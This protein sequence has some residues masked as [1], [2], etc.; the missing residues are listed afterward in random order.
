MN[1]TLG[2][3][4]GSGG[5]GSSGAIWSTELRARGIG[6]FFGAAFLALWL[7]GWLVGECFAL[8]MAGGILVK[9]LAPGVLAQLGPKIVMP[10]GMAAAGIL[11][12][13]ALWLTLWTV[14]GIAAFAQLMRMLGGV[15][16]IELHPT[17]LLVRR[18][19]IIGQSTTRIPIERVID[20]RLSP[21]KALV[22]ET[23]DR[24]ETLSDLEG[25]EQRTAAMI[26]LRP[27]VRSLRSDSRPLRERLA[28]DVPEGWSD[29]AADVMAGGHSGFNAVLVSRNR[30]RTGA[31]VFL[32]L[33]A[34]IPAGIIGSALRDTVFLRPGVEVT[35]AGLIGPLV[36]L[37]VLALIGAAHWTWR[38]E[39]RV[40]T[41][42]IETY[43]EVLW[44]RH[45]KLYESARLELEAGSDS[46]GDAWYKLEV[47]SGA[48]HGTLASASDYSGPRRLGMW[49][50][51]RLGSE[52]TLPREL[53]D[54]PQDAA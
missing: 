43:L 23:P 38:R 28:V 18:R 47:W 25:F 30:G 45:T 19:G 32:G 21:R 4:G 51:R 52:L 48:D 53:R 37:I 26:A 36:M 44:H 41:G 54:E 50:A 15:D 14:G 27:Q 11:G 6:R 16:R 3:S 12:F 33:I 46:D 49:L 34:A 8:T 7:C 1:P 9:L 20:V 29:A 39:I 42:A 22:A 35:F 17:A 10:E 2:T 31:I 40:R 13:L 5:E 24:V